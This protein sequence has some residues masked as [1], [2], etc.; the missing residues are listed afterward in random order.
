[1]DA[2]AANFSIS[3]FAL[4]VAGLTEHIKSVLEE[5]RT[6][7]QVWVLGEV[8]SAKK[9]SSG[10]FF[11][12]QDEDGTAAVNCVV[13]RSQLPR[14]AN[15]PEVGE[16]ITVLGSVR[17]YPQRSNY[18]LTVWQV[19]PTGDGLRA[20]RYRQLRQRLA[21]EG[22]FDPEQKRPLPTF[23]RRLAVVT[24]PQAAAWGDIQR[25]LR[26]HHP[27]LPVIFSPA[28]VQGEQA[29]TSIARAIAR[30]VEDSRA[31]VLILSRGGGAV[32]D[33]ECFND[34]QVVRAIAICPIP[35]V[36]GIGH[37]RDESLADLAA[38]VCAH[39][40]TA[41]VVAAVPALDDLEAEHQER[42]HQATVLVQEAL[43]EAELKTLAL[44][45]RLQ[46][47]RLDRQLH[48]EQAHLR[49][50]KQRLLQAI[51]VTLRQAEE[52]C[53]SL[54][55]QL[56]TLD[57]ESVLRRGYALVR[58]SGQVVTQAEDLVLGQTLDIQLARGR[59]SAQ[60]T[61]IIPESTFPESSP[62]ESTFN[63]EKPF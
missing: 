37:Q 28:T 2:F 17:V 55:E 43:Y 60:V 52:R 6:L 16:Q 41:A 27:G 57:P 47:L 40:P 19:L 26:Q 62:P 9:H 22:L 20:L 59:V 25:T 4:S 18:Q 5:D 39:T 44:R 12:L 35:I 42:L 61:R 21:A 1:M 7:R 32:E 34:E 8:S 14:L 36:T 10:L 46:R 56:T 58:Q 13:W 11:T 49:Q 3:S 53:V 48:Q 54:K 45:Q 50:L 30:V 23:P 31:D 24:S 29:P 63:C 15:V 33:L 51:Q 38:D